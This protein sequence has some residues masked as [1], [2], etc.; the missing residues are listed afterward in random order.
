LWE[1]IVHTQDS[2]PK[3]KSISVAC[4]VTATMT[5]LTH[6]P[7]HPKLRRGEEAE[8]KREREERIALLESQR[9]EKLK[10]LEVLKTLVRNQLGHCTRNERARGGGGAHTASM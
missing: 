10:Q 8:T 2:D 9:M 6:P 1:E 3:S 4:A 7:P 5:V